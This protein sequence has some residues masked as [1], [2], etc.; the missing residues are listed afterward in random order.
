MIQPT[1]AALKHPNLPAWRRAAIALLTLILLAAGQTGHAW[2]QEKKTLPYTPTYPYN[3]KTMKGVEKNAVITTYLRSCFT[4]AQALPRK[5]LKDFRTCQDLGA[6]APP[7]DIVEVQ[8]GY[9]KRVLKIFAEFTNGVRIQYG[10]RGMDF[11]TKMPR[12][13]HDQWIENE[14]E[15]TVSCRKTLD[16]VEQCCTPV[17]D[18]KACCVWLEDAPP[19]CE[20]FAAKPSKN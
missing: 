6:G 3:P 2:A 4:A 14:K 17:K 8:A 9:P 5:A 20:Y 12:Q 18:D 11:V 10:T 15:A 19:V 7:K 16:H 13:P 1:L